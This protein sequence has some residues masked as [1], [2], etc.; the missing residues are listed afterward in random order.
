M[1][2]DIRSTEGTSMETHRSTSIALTLAVVLA[3]S[4]IAASSAFAAESAPR[5]KVGGVFLANGTSRKLED[6]SFG[7]VLFR[8]PGLTGFN[9]KSTTCK[10]SSGKI[11]GSAES[12][13]GLLKELKLF[14]GALTVE[15]MSCSS[16][17]TSKP[18]AGTLVWLAS[19]GGQAGIKLTAEA[20]PA[21]EMFHFTITGCALAGEYQATGE[22]IAKVLP[23]ETEQIE[24]EFQLPKAA[25]CTAANAL[26]G[27]WNNK[28]AR[29]AQSLG[30]G[31]AMN[32]SPAQFCGNFKMWLAEKTTAFGVFPG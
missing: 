30:T 26:T 9:L 14:C 2:E 13:P 20:G 11:V 25:E 23:V 8:A 5:W 15:G 31:F 32:A 19:S 12:K 18:I 10:L 27:W 1:I 22:L 17:V 24:D 29:E 3:L 16:T 6:Q 7:E 28:E 21:S 4:A